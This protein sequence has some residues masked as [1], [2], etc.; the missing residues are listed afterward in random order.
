MSVSSPGENPASLS[1][2]QPARAG[3]LIDG[4]L[5]SFHQSN[6]AE[7]SMAMPSGT[8]ALKLLRIR[9]VGRISWLADDVFVLRQIAGEVLEFETT[10]Q[11]RLA[12]EVTMTTPA[13]DCSRN[14]DLLR[15]ALLEALAGER[16]LLEQTV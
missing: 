15:S 14:A 8:Q 3:G 12:A 2:R 13:P 9:W 16:V 5:E 10:A 7:G 11:A 1:L 4:R 6:G